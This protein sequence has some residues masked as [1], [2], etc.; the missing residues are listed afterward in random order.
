[1]QKK[2]EENRMGFS[3]LF[4]ETGDTKGTLHAKIGTIKERNS[5]H[6][7]KQTGLPN[8]LHVI[9]FLVEALQFFFMYYNF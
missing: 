6:L 4:K 1:M 2:I 7:Q 5:K 8:I 3:D 9:F